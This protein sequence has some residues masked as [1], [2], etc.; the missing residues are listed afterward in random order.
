MDKILF[1]KKSVGWALIWFLALV[2][3]GMT[4]PVFLSQQASAMNF[5]HVLEEPSFAHWFGTDSLGR[6][7]F[8][9]VLCGS[10]VSLGVSIL[11]VGI[12]ILIGVTV[13]ACAGYFGGWIDKLLMGIVDVFL[14]FPVFFLILA[15]IAIL[16]PGI[17]H[18]FLIIGL[19]GWMSAARLVRAEILSLKEREFILASR[20]LGAGDGWILFRHL[21]PNALGPVVVNAVLGLSSAILLEG[22][23]SF[24]GVGVQPPTPSWGNI[25]MDGKSALGVAWWPTFFPGAM[26]FLTILS[27]NVL[28]QA[29]GPMGNEHP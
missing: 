3:I 24:L 12:A 29:L 23:L 11:A 2:V 28:G 14:C 13:G 26:I 27:A 1:K 8:A 6:D 22:A 7:L 9:R 21:V 17:F 19:T 25:L 5:K 10:R 20:A 15:V 4:A 18:I 16:G